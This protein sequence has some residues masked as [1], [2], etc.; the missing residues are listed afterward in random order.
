MPLQ[1]IL[2][3]KT[4]EILMIHP[5][6]LVI[7]DGFGI[8]SKT[9]YNAIFAAKTPHFGRWLSL[10]PHTTLHASGPFV[11][12]PPHFQGNSEVGHITIGAGR[13]IKQ[14]L[15]IW[16]DAIKN[17]SF[18]TNKALQNSFNHLKTNGNTLH[19]MGLLSDAGIHCHE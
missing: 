15:T 8:S 10:Y 5:T 13:I 6:V 1:P 11:G 16:F 17:G 19:I 7:L 3:I 14:P 12:L 2:S 9:A 4:M 18:F